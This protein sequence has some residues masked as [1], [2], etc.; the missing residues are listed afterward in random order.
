MVVPQQDEQ[1]FER[2]WSHWLTYLLLT[3]PFELLS[4]MEELIIRE[5]IVAFW[6]SGRPLTCSA[7]VVTKGSCGADRFG[8]GNLCTVWV[9]VKATSWCCNELSDYPLARLEWK[10]DVHFHPLSWSLYG[11]GV[12]HTGAE[13]I[14]LISDSLGL[15]RVPLKSFLQRDLVRNLDEIPLEHG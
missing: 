1:V 3:W 12:S 7:H 13:D 11:W 4:R 10:K 2:V 15:Q 6:I 5:S 14:I 8:V 9:S